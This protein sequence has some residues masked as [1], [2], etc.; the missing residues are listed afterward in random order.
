MARQL[1]ACRSLARRNLAAASGL[2]TTEPT[3]K[4][5]HGWSATIL[6]TSML[7]MMPTGCF[8]CVTTNR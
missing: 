6:N 2:S 4:T 3:Q 7:V 1:Y 8:P 5:I